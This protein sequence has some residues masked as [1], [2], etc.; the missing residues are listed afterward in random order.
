MDGSWLESVMESLEKGE[1]T[2]RLVFKT[3]SSS[4]A[5]V[6]VMSDV[7]ARVEGTTLSV[8]RVEAPWSCEDPRSW[9]AWEEGSAQVRLCCGGEEREVSVELEPVLPASYPSQDPRVRPA[10]ECAEVMTLVVDFSDEKGK[11]FRASGVFGVVRQES[12][13]DGQEGRI[14]VHCH[15]GSVVVIDAVSG[16]VVTDRFNVPGSVQEHSFFDGSQFAPFCCY[17]TAGDRLEGGEK[18]NGRWSVF[19]CFEK[20]V[21][22]PPSS[23]GAKKG[24]MRPM[25]SVDCRNGVADKR[26]MTCRG[27]SRLCGVP[28]LLRSPA[29]FAG[30]RT[31]LAADKRHA[32][33]LEVTGVQ[34]VDEDGDDL[35]IFQGGGRMRATVTGHVLDAYMVSVSV[36]SSSNFFEV[37][38]ASGGRVP[39]AVRVVLSSGGFV[40][41]VPGVAVVAASAVAAP[42]APLP[43]AMLAFEVQIAEL[44]RALAAKRVEMAAEGA[45]LEEARKKEA[46]RLE[47]ARLAEVRRKEEEA[48][49]EAARARRLEDMKDAARKKMEQRRLL[50]EAEKRSKEED[51]ESRERAEDEGDRLLGF[52]YSDV[53]PIEEEEDEDGAL[54][55]LAAA[56]AAASA[57]AASA[58]AL[59][60]QILEKK[61]GKKLPPPPTLPLPVPSVPSVPS[62]PAPVPSVPSVPRKR[63]KNGGE[64]S[65]SRVKITSAYAVATKDGSGTAEEYASRV[66]AFVKEAE[67]QAAAHP[68]QA[69]S[70]GVY[71]VTRNSCR[72]FA[73]LVRRLDGKYECVRLGKIWDTAAEFAAD[74]VVIQLIG[75]RSKDEGLT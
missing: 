30:T 1:A 73:L 70:A 43:P 67:A 38:S 52:P 57:A 22:H 46:A 12:R 26:K 40:E 64:V 6:R 17:E 53:Q 44:E 9:L 63:A 65:P 45:R 16:D 37:S 24:V 54:A 18:T 61:S 3:T 7:G 36:G 14:D 11:E 75:A 58:A 49:E 59:R 5:P 39:D 23:S 42:A 13:F 20:V 72:A 68:T 21:M 35:A 56:D 48:A 62:V 29:P 50:E 28:E 66:M 69:F 2:A 27:V 71:L 32:V 60:A 19:V 55:A 51:R 10:Y 8:R 41:Q 25:H 4:E 34:E 33:T 47:E 74:V 31:F 15:I